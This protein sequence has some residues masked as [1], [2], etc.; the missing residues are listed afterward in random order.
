[1]SNNAMKKKKTSNKYARIQSRVERRKRRRTT[2]ET[3]V[4]EEKNKNELRV[5]KQN[6]LLWHYVTF[7]KHN[8]HRVNNLNA[9]RDERYRCVLQ[10]STDFSKSE[11]L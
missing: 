11:K 8:F 2:I 6:C 4:F 5:R 9:L 3:C 10:A 1:M 7:Y